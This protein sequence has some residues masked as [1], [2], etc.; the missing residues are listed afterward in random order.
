METANEELQSANEELETTNEELQSTNEELE[1]TNEELQSTNEELETMNEELQST[2]E[3]L[4]TT[5]DELQVR[6]DELNQANAFLH[7]VLGS[8]KVGIAVINSRFEVIAW[9]EKAQ[10]MWGVS[11]KDAQ[12]RS[13]F[14]L[15]I[16]LPLDKVNTQIRACL[17]GNKNSAEQ[18][19]QAVGRRGKRVTCK[20]LCKVFAGPDAKRGVT[21][22]MEE[23]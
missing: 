12:G 10:D 11:A 6:T 18:V 2:N 4:E 16:G 5:N 8:L 3:E 9:N 20:V 23:A 13:I 21:I 17:N 14:D 22:V 7:A 1:T 19:L 15:G